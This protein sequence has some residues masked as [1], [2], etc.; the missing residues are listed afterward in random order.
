MNDFSYTS[1]LFSFSFQT[2]FILLIF[3]CTMLYGVTVL[4]DVSDAALKQPSKDV[5][6]FQN[7]AW[8]KNR[9]VLSAL[10]IVSVVVIVTAVA[11]AL[12][13]A[14]SKNTPLSKAQL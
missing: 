2:Q 8:L 11:V 10:V 3:H 7:H 4:F 5:L 9:Y 1:C 12:S 6:T 13:E 14:E